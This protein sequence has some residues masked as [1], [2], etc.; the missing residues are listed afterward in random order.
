MNEK[1]TFL[2]VKLD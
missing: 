2:T 1:F